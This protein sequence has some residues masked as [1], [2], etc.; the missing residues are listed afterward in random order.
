MFLVFSRFLSCLSVCCLGFFSA[1][2]FP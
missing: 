1:F 2:S